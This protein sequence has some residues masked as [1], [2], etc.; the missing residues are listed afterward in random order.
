MNIF[1]QLLAA[2]AFI[3]V[4]VW[5]YYPWLVADLAVEPTE[6]DHRSA[7]VPGERFLVYEHALPSG[8]ILRYSDGTREYVTRGRLAV[9]P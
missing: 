4:V 7:F 9:W 6:D 3:A 5:I 1:L 2:A 8:F